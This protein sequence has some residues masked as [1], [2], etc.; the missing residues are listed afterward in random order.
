MGADTSSAVPRPCE[1]CGA[2]Y[3]LLRIVRSLFDLF[4]AGEVAGRLGPGNPDVPAEMDATDLV[5]FDLAADRPFGL[6]RE[7]G[8]LGHRQQLK[9]IEVVTVIRHGAAIYRT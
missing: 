8:E 4:V 5:V 6:F 9:R 3:V 2:L 7:L 1:R